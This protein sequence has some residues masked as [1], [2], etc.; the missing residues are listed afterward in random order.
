MFVYIL[1]RDVSR[2]AGF[3]VESPIYQRP[4]LFT[5][6]MKAKIEVIS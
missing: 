1:N 3:Q 2:Q 4:N 5:A 6:K